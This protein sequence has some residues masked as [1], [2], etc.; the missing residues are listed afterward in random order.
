MR[1]AKTTKMKDN[2]IEKDGEQRAYDEH[3]DRSIDCEKCGQ[4]VGHKTI[5]DESYNYCKDCNW[6]TH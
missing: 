5:G 3:K 1:K 6:V 2:Y 4:E